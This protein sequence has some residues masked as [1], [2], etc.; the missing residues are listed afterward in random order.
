[1]DTV[2]RTEDIEAGCDIAFETRWKRFQHICWVIMALLLLG[3]V[4]GALGSG[5]LSKATAVSVDGGVKTHYERLAR[6]ETPAILEL[7]LDKSLISSGQ[8]QIRLNREY[9]DRLRIKQIIPQPA[10]AELLADGARFTFHTDP[11]VESATVLFIQDPSTPG[12][13]VGE[14]E[15]SGAAPLRLHHFVYP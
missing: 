1:M 14:V 3:G 15:V 11:A 9:V 13:V 7:R 12:L 10:A 8:V 4:S 6:R 2:H 5:P